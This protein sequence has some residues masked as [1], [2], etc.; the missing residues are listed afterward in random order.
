M[1]RYQILSR[2]DIAAISALH[3]AGHS[4]RAISD[5]AGVSVRQVQRYVKRTGELGGNKIP[6][7]KKPPGNTRKTSLR[8]LRVV[9]REVQ[10]NPR[11][12]ARKIREDNL[13]L[14]SN[15]SVRTLSRRIHDDLQYLSYA[16]RPKPV[17]T[18]A[19][20]KKRLAFCDRMK[21]WTIEQ[22]RGVLW[23]DES[24]FTVQT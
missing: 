12:S 21:D 2:D 24:R 20:E 14:L 7:K 23:S 9:H 3:Q 22:W 15:V 11:V 6:A 16:A 1:V 10:R 5:Q 19:Q 17:V 8:T 13:G 4:T 18:V